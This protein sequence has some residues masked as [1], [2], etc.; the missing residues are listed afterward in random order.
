MANRSS[1]GI[2]R[3]GPYF[4]KPEFGLSATRVALATSA[5]RYSKIAHAFC[6]WGR[7]MP[8]PAMMRRAA[9]E[10]SDTICVGPSGALP[11]CKAPIETARS[12]DLLA[13][14]ACGQPPQLARLNQPCNV[15]IANKGG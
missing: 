14:D 10:A 13:K 15:A 2:L 4:E 9:D 7:R 1:Q 3:T 8:W 11:F 5:I 6:N 12:A